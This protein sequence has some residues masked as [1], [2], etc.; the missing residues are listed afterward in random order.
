[1]GHAQPPFESTR[2]HEAAERHFARCSNRPDPDR[3]F[4]IDSCLLSLIVTTRQEVPEID[5]HNRSHWECAYVE[6][7]SLLS[8]DVEHG[9]HFYLVSAA[10]CNPTQVLSELQRLA[11]WYAE[12]R[13]PEI[14]LLLLQYQD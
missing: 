10:N 12:L 6:E 11:G 1:M 14:D 3:E 4:S 8:V 5:A 7:V 13:S 2:L 9:L